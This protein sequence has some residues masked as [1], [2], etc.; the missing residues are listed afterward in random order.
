MIKIN[1]II[2]GNKELIYFF[3]IFLFKITIRQYGYNFFQQFS[4]FQ[5]F[6]Y[7]FSF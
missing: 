2:K 7:F 1:R 5:I 3:L 6:R 4:G